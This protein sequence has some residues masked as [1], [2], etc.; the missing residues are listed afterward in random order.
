M[1]NYHENKAKEVKAK[2]CSYIELHS[3]KF[4]DDN[5]FYSGMKKYMDQL[6][7]LNIDKVVLD[8]TVL[9]KDEDDNG[10]LDRVIKNL[11]L[12]LV[13][14]KSNNIRS[15]QKLLTETNSNI[16]AEQ[17]EHLTKHTEYIN[18]CIRPLKLIYSKLYEE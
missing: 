10:E 14:A 17:E 7:T 11:Q 15:I 2:I 13:E 18:D 5:E 6:D 1:S 12:Q 3:L 8:E 4:I 9:Q 16:I